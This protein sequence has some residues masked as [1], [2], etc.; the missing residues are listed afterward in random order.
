MFE[1]LDNVTKKRLRSISQTMYDIEHGTVSQR[2]LEE[3]YN[4]DTEYYRDELQVL[5]MWDD[6]ENIECSELER[7]KELVCE[8]YPEIEEAYLPFAIKDL[9]HEAY[10]KKESECYGK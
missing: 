8:I 9:M 2:K 10:E 6:A 7:L 5:G 4:E 1:K 3:F